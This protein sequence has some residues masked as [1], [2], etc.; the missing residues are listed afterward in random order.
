[1]EGLSGS[2][3][4]GRAIATGGDA[5]QLGCSRKGRIAKTRTGRAM[6]L[7][8]CSPKSTKVSRSLSRT[9]RQASSDKQTLPGSQIAWSLAAMFTPS[10]MRSPSASSMTSPRC[11]P[12]R[13]SMRRSS[14]RPAFCARR[15]SPTSSEQ[16]TASTTLANSTMIPSPMRLTTRPPVLGD[17]GVE[18]V[19]SEAHEAGQACPLR[20]PLSGG[21]SRRR[22]PPKSQRACASRPSAP[23][24]SCD[25]RHCN[26][27]CDR[28][29]VM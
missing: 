13:I 28:L 21:Y 9:W 27:I 4:C 8:V 1:M 6:F 7:R 15:P 19:E 23:H 22:R 17:R 16:R 11:M 26:T 14:A 10:P 12:V 18:K 2:A 24:G 3:S 29:P 20:P 25:S 5:D